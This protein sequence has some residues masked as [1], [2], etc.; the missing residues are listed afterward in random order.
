VCGGVVGEGGGSG[1][2]GGHRGGEGGEEGGEWE[3]ELHGCLVGS[4]CVML[5]RCEGSR[6]DRRVVSWLDALETVGCSW[7]DS[8]MLLGSRSGN[9]GKVGLVVCEI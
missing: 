7:R 1:D 3:G 6:G 9:Y 2:A 8:R 4:G 5:V